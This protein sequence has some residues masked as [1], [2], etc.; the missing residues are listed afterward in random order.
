MQLLVLFLALLGL[1]SAF[2]HGGQRSYNG[3][4]DWNGDMRN[5]ADEQN[6][7]DGA[8]EGFVPPRGFGPPYNR[9][10]EHIRFGRK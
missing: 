3:D 8:S 5:L 9:Q 2:W 6:F 7:D 10:F 4:N 1:S